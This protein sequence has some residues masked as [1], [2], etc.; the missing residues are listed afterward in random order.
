M[1]F[2][3]FH[4]AWGDLTADSDGWSVVD[5]FNMFLENWQ[6]AFAQAASAP[7]PVYVDVGTTAAQLNDIIATAVDNTEIVLR[8]GTHIFDEAIVIDRDNITLKGE[9]Q[10]ATVVQ[11]AFAAGSED[12]GI[13]VTGG[14]KV[15]VGV[16]NGA[17][18]SGDS[19]I[20][21]NAGHGLTAGDMVYIYQANTQQYLDDNGWT[22][23]SWDDADTRPF[24]ETVLR[25]ENVSG[26]DI[27]FNHAIPYD[28]DA[29]AA[30][31]FT[32]DAAENVTLSD[33]TITYD[34]GTANPYDFVNAAAGFS[35]TSA[36]DLTATW[37]ASLSAISIVDAA[38]NGVSINT[39]I[40][41]TGDDI[42]VSGS[43]NKGGGGNG[44]GIELHEASFNSLTNLDLQDMR[45]SLVFSAWNAENDN[46]IHITDTNRDINFHGSPDSGNVVTV[47]YA[48]LDYDPAQNTSGGNAIWKIVASGGASHAATDIWGENTVVFTHGQASSANDTIYGR[49]GGAYLNGKF[50][51]DTLVGGAGDDLIVGGTRKD[52]LTGGQGADTFLFRMGD[53]LDTITDFQFGAGG[54]T[55]IFSNNPSV[56]D[57]SDLTITQSGNNVKIRYGSNSTVVLKDHV[58]ADV[59]ASNI[60]YDPTGMLTAQ[61]YF[62]IDF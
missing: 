59:D 39:S 45:H 53:D 50:G 2:R 58:V 32:F 37:G 10:A 30:K 1:S 21:L 13:E 57:F 15:Y 52:T 60:Q 20:T 8:N 43:H 42:L 25:V 44:Y 24:R 34:L 46:I 17:I 9:S 14:S 31:V 6:M 48:A 16:A 33:M 5:A 55:L 23:V 41:L 35:G 56:V 49:D 7:Q 54:D 29:G 61:D 3:H 18:T 51:Y 47:D 62:G 12:N 28:M 40:D 19:T 27:T 4:N 36:I 22:N 38:S 11:F 26:N